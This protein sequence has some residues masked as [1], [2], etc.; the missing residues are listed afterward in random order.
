MRELKKSFFQTILQ[1]TVLA[2]FFRQSARFSTGDDLTLSLNQLYNLPAYL[3]VNSHH[4][5]RN[6]QSENQDSHLSLV[7]RTKEASQYLDDIRILNLINRIDHQ[8]SSTTNNNTSNLTIP[9]L[10]V[11]PAT[12]FASTSSKD[13]INLSETRLLLNSIEL[14]WSNQFTKEVII[15][16]QPSNHSLVT[17]QFLRILKWISICK[18]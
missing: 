10:I 1:L 11:A 6:H 2:Y 9:Y 14:N 18:Q 12:S 5:H 17:I 8:E 13:L 3:T 15:S 16:S 7:Y 4:P